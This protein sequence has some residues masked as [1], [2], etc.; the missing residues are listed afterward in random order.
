MAA[1]PEVADARGGSRPGQYAR[2][3]RRDH[4]AGANQLMSETDRRRVSPK[5]DGLAEFVPSAVTLTRRRSPQ[6]LATHRRLRRAS[7]TGPRAGITEI[8]GESIR[9][10]HLGRQPSVGLCG[11]VALT[12]RRARRDDPEHRTD[13]RLCHRARSMSATL[14]AGA[15][16]QEACRERPVGLH[17]VGRFNPATTDRHRRIVT[18]APAPTS[19]LVGH[20]DVRRRA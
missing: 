15:A 4:Q 7:C 11:Q 20:A 10:H 16:G 2:H 3:I 12:S 9:R 5:I 13:L 17:R 19:A 14:C 6:S 18:D 1:A 8:T